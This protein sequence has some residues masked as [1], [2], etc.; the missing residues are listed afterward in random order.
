MESYLKFVMSLNLNIMSKCDSSLVL[1]KP[2]LNC[3]V[4]QWFKLPPN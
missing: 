3:T 1:F 2:N 4:Q